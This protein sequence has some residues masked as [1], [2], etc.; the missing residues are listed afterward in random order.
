M[1]KLFAILL[2][3]MMLFSLTAIA[4]APAPT[5][6][7]V[8]D[9]VFTDAK[10]LTKVLDEG[11]AVYG[12]RLEFAGEWDSGALLPA[13][14][15]VNGYSIVQVYMNNSGKPGHAELKGKYVFII[16]DE[17]QGIGAGLTNT[18][19]YF[20][21]SNTLRDLTLNVQFTSRQMMFDAKGYIHLEVD[22]FEI[23]SVSDADGY[24]TD[25]RLYIPE[26]WEG[27][28]LPL[29]IW[30]HGAGERGTNNF[31]QLSAN[32]SALNYITPAAQ[33]RNPAFVLAPQGHSGWDGP[34]INNINTIVLELIEKYNIDAARIYV[35]GCSMGGGGSKSLMFAYPEM[36]AASVVIANANLSEDEARLAAYKDI[37]IIVITG[38]A[39]GGGTANERMVQNYELVTSLGYKAVAFLSENGRN[40]YLRGEEAAMDL[41]PV[42]DAMA[43]EEAMWAFVTYLPGTVIPSAHWSWMAATENAALQ[44][45]MFSKVKAVPYSGK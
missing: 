10:I 33:K 22:D 14:F 35:S 43:K 37:P 34:A 36:I 31:T 13:D 16:F 39:D 7:P 3:A 27:K 6:T 41:Q 26:G 5:A 20:S 38:A 9:P 12:V 29:V 40:G 32:R 21:G 17:P 19:Q 23:G 15:G 11:Q 45:W 4:E 30:L 42:I 28:S 25:Y 8:P 24:K 44:D 18:L 2:C 1:K